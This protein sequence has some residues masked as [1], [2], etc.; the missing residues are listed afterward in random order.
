MSLT[1]DDVDD[2]IHMI[3]E[4]IRAE[5]ADAD[6][7]RCCG[8]PLAADREAQALVYHITKLIPGEV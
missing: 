6:V 2:I 7:C 8:G 3:R 1:N 5:I 4:L